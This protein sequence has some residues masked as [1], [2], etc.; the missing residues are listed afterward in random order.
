M[1]APLTLATVLL[2]AFNAGSVEAAPKQCRDAKGKFVKCEPAQAATK[3]R[4]IKTKKFAKCGL[5]GTEPVA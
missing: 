1:R 4:D 3:C 2:F 5:P